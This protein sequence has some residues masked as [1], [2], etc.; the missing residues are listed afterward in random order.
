[1][2][3]EQLAAAPGAILHF[4]TVLGG[5]VPSYNIP[6]VT[7]NL[8]FTGAVLAEIY[9]GKITKWNDP[10]VTKLN[11]GVSLPGT[12]I[13]VVH[14]SDGSGTTYILSLIHISEPTRLGMIS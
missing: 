1:M 13:A 4:P 10:A 7:A 11:P 5:V 8:K 6:G 3:N 12:D 9:L 2:T 14:R